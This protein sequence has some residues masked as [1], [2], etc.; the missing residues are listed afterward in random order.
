MVWKVIRFSDK[1]VD[2]EVE[3]IAAINLEYLH[4]LRAYKVHDPRFNPMLPSK[5][6]AAQLSRSQHAPQQA[7]GYRL[8]FAQRSCSFAGV[9][10]RLIVRHGL[11]RISFRCQCT[12]AK[13]LNS[14]TT[15]GPLSQELIS[16]IKIPSTRGRCRK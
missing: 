15:W 1:D 16:S 9:S 13:T 10:V 3:A 5:L 2:Q 8:R 6:Q 4:L 11:S 7:L 12:S 14:I